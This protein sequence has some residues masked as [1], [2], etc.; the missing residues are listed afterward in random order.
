MPKIRGMKFLFKVLVR[1]F[2]VLL[3]LLVIAAGAVFA[4]SSMKLRKTHEITFTPGAVP[5]GDAALAQGKHLAETRGCMDCHG[6]DLAGHTVMN[7]AAMGRID[8]PNLTR[9]LGGVPPSF[10]DADWER[11][12]RYGVASDGRGLFLMPSTDYAQLSTEDMGALIAYLKSLPPVDHPLVPVAPGPVSRLLLTLGKIKLAADVI[13]H[14]AVKP[15]AATPGATAEYG[16]YV[17]LSC[18]GCH[19]SNYS[20]GRIPS[21]PPDWPPAANLTPDPAGRLTKW[22]ETDFITALRTAKRPDGTEISPVMPRAFAQ[23]TDTELKAL[24]LFIKTLP[25]AATGSR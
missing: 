4:V 23:M 16:R 9:G 14:S 5:T 2:L 3:L 25:A 1:L 24:W 8:G 15:M 10:S 19:G 17:A 6:K 12:I 20:G 11:A 18:T 13:D 7:N 21:G 22:G